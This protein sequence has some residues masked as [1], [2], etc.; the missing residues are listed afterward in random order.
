M[1]RLLEYLAPEPREDAEHA[2]DCHA[3]RNRACQGLLRCT[4]LKALP[5]GARAARVAAEILAAAD[6]ADF[7][8]TLRMGF[9]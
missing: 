9:R 3:S 8:S 5:R 1:A 7:T 6:A 4:A 2:Q